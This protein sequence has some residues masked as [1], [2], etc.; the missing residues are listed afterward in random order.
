MF[1]EAKSNETKPKILCVGGNDSNQVFEF[2]D[3]FCKSMKAYPQLPVEVSGHRVAKLSNF[4]YCVGGWKTNKVYL[5]NLNEPELK[6]R[7]VA[8]MNEERES[9]GC[10][11]FNGKLVVAAGQYDFLE[12]FNVVELYEE[13]SNIWRTISSL[14]KSRTGHELVACEGRLYA[15]GGWEESSV[16]CLNDV[17]K[18]WKEIEPMK[19]SRSDFAAVNCGGYIY[20]IGGSGQTITQKSVE[21]YS[22]NSNKWIDV[23]AMNFDRRGHSACLVQNKILVVGGKNADYEFVHEVECFDA[24]SDT[25]SIVGETDVDLYYHVLVVI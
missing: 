3:S 15:M 22:P 11:V 23:A 25:W 10:A 18:K 7:E 13:Q 8:S 20:A 14:N 17:D 24:T 2:S 19:T 6:W 21:K 16:E 9:F 5:M 1:R 4:I 12:D